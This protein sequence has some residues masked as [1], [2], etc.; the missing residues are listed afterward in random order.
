MTTEGREFNW[1]DTIKEDGQNFEPLPEGDYNV[2][3]EKFERKQIQRKWKT[4]GMQ[5]GSGLF[6][7]TWSR[8]R[9]YNPG[10]LCVAQL[11]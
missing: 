4:S 9:R 8:Q 10:E 5:H 3:V 2:T 7:C 11:S 6:Y 1:D